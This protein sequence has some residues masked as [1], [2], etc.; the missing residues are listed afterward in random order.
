VHQAAHK[1]EVFGGA[2]A[3]LSD[4]VFVDRR[5]LAHGAGDI[6]GTKV[7]RR[8]AHRHDLGRELTVVA[9]RDVVASDRSPTLATY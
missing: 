8:V 4:V 9:R 5:V 7:V 1:A 6:G 2:V 3:V